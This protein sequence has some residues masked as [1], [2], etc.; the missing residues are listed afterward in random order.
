MGE[1][2]KVGLNPLI[3][4]VVGAVAGAAA[5]IFSDKKNR[6]KVVKATGDLKDKGE[7]KLGEIGQKAVD[8]KDEGRDKLVS[9]LESAKK[10][11][12]GPS[13]KKK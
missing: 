7:K 12:E 9:G 2:S 4:A 1:K 3:A 8:L 10:K 6:D 5:V 13:K 11:L